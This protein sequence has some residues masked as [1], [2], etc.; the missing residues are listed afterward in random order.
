MLA[1]RRKLAERE[2]PQWLSAAD[3]GWARHVHRAADTDLNR[4]NEC[5]RCSHDLV[6][7]TR[8]LPKLPIS[9]RCPRWPCLAKNRA[10]R[11]LKLCLSFR[12]PDRVPCTQAAESYTGNPLTVARFGCKIPASRQ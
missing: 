12:A 3:L 11:L 10:A 7:P 6:A 2:Y 8:S 9:L 5:R 4:E 1:Q